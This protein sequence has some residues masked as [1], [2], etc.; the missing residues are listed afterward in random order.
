MNAEPILQ[1]DD[2]RA[3]YGDLTVIWDL[4]L[5]L[6][7]GRTTALLGRNGAGKTTLLSAI[8]GL[9]PLGHGRILFG[10]TDISHAS[11]WNRTRAGLAFVQEGKRVLRNLTV[12]ENLLLGLRKGPGKQE[13]RDILE[14]AYDRFPALR[15]RRGAKTGTLSGGQ[16]QMV[17]LATAMVSRPSVLLIDEPSSGLAPVVVDEVFRAVEQFKQDGTAVLLVEQ[18][19]DEVLSGYADDVVVLDQGKVALSGVAGEIAA[20]EVLAGVHG[21]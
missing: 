15:D 5:T 1:V 12:H 9:L 16:Q 17:A 18:L 13:S 20:E 19:V 8:A 21:R 14:T 11:P 2:V 7:R 3:G 4:S 6:R 10:G